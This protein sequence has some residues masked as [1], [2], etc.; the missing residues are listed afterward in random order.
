MLD[1]VEV[2]HDP[3]IQ[4]GDVVRVVDR[5][6][7]E[8]N[9][10]AWVVGLRTTCAA[11]G[12]PQQTLT[13]RGTSYNGVPV[14]AGL[15]PDG[16]VDTGAP[17]GSAAP[18]AVRALTSAATEPRPVTPVPIDDPDARAGDDGMDLDHL[19]PPPWEQ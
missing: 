15:T 16:P 17:P 9:T 2:L 10:L 5:A 4:L 12:V 6:G 8:L 3:R 14:D 18:R 1:A 11:G 7:A 13:L 19:L